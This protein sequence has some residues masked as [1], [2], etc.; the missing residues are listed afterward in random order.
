MKTKNLIIGLFLIGFSTIL[1]AQ[2]Y[3][4]L[5]EIALKDKSDYQK[6]E[7]LVLECANYILNS[8]YNLL[9]KDLNHTNAQLFI[10]KWMGGTPDYMFSIDETIGKAT[11]SSANLLAVYL[12][13]SVKYVLE[14]KE[15]ASNENEVKYN[16]ILLFLDYCKDATKNVK[17]NGEIK[18]MIK[19]NE[20]N[21]L[22]EYL[23][24]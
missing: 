9:D 24:L 19:A 7:S 2:D 4:K 12:A 17:V 6:N 11:K 22:R 10:I 23:K 14:N 5:K 15:M 21:T 3:T 13:A 18:K 1:G 20:E 8:Q 16:S